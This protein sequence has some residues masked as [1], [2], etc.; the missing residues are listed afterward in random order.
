M[1]KAAQVL[2]GSHDFQAFRS[3]SCESKNTKKTI[4]SIQWKKHFLH[5]ADLISIFFEGS[6]FLKQ[7]IR[8][9]VGSLVEIGLEKQTTTLF[10][11]VL[12]NGNAE[13]L[14]FTAP[15]KGL[16]LEKILVDYPKI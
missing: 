15:A 1:K 5:P 13:F 10:S 12:K 2:E 7:M 8:I 6:G 3:S 11:E 16:F 14:K 4:F 9:I